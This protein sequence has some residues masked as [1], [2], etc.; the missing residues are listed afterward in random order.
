MSL[1]EFQHLNFNSSLL[2]TV[3]ALRILR[4]KNGVTAMSVQNADIRITVPVQVFIP[5]SVP[6]AAIRILRRLERCFTR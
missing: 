3:N 4:Q 6:A 5:G 1:F 2:Q